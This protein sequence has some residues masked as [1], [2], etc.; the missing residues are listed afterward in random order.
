MKED[1]DL[2]KILSDRIP[3]IKVPDIIKKIELR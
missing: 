2:D 3:I 1:N